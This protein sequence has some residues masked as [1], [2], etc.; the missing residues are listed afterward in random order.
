ME[1]MG[2]D[3]AEFKWPTEGKSVPGTA[4]QNVHAK[5]KSFEETKVRRGSRIREER[6]AA[7]RAGH[8]QPRSRRHAITNNG[9]RIGGVTIA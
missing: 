6:T 2:P 7:A 9:Q 3:F 8:S 1:A 5:C 4:G